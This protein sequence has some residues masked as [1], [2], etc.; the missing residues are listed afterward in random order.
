MNK[1]LVIIP[2][3]N[4]AMYIQETLECILKQ[5]FRNF[6]LLIIDDGS[7]DESPKL[8]ADYVKNYYNSRIA[9]QSIEFISEKINSG[10]PSTLNTAF[11]IADNRKYDFVIILAS[12]DLVEPTWVEEMVKLQEKTQADFVSTAGRRFGES[13]LPFPECSAGLYKIKTWIEL[14][15]RD[16]AK[17]A[18]HDVDF[19]F[20]LYAN[21]KRKR[22]VNKLLYLWR[23]Y[24]QQGSR[25]WG[26]TTQA[27]NQ[28]MLEKSIPPHKKVEILTKDFN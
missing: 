1:H 11:I 2:N 21:G 23:T 15:G 25:Q 3:H 17:P 5:T 10:I 6:D 16:E 22:I 19:K 12:D 7:T 4:K 18:I 26:D 24:P 8:I 28:A 14:G 27:V 13:T 9:P 20:K